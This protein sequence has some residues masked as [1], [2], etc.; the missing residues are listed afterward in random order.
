MATNDIAF[1]S[2][3]FKRDLI[4][5]KTRIPGEILKTYSILQKAIVDATLE[6]TRSK[7]ISC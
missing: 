3:K 2:F 1:K 5:S 7:Y 6:E 4:A